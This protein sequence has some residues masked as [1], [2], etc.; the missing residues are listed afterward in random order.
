MLKV[1]KKE[2]HT[3]LVL[4][5]A[6]ES[7]LD[8]SQLVCQENGSIIVSVLERQS[9]RYIKIKKKKKK[10]ITLETVVKE[11]LLSMLLNSLPIKL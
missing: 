7:V 9:V 3:V 10:K 8:W 11:I 4:Q 5:L 6:S 1:F 2:C